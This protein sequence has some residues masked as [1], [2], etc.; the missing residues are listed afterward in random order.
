ME[1]LYRG[2]VE[3]N[4]KGSIDKFKNGEKLKTFEEIKKLKS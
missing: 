1:S 3:T 2:F 4:G